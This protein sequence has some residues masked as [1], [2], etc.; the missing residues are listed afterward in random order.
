MRRKEG[1]EGL[2]ELGAHTNKSAMEG[3][4]YELAG[5]APIWGGIPVPKQQETVTQR[6][7]RD[8]RGTAS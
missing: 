1:E 2:T 3:Y 4:W 7:V 6:G 8:K 5:G